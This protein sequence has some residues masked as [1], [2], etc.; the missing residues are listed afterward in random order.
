LSRGFLISRRQ[1]QLPVQ[2]TER[3][4]VLRLALDHLPVDVV[5]EQP[6]IDLREKPTGEPFGDPHMKHRLAEKLIQVER[7]TAPRSRGHSRNHLWPE[8]IDRA[9]I[10]VRAYVM[11]FIDKDEAKERQ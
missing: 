6:I 10:R 1:N 3:V 5:R 2:L 9:L 11:C 7:V 8:C 4:L